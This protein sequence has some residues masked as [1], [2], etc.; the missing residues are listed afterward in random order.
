MAGPVTDAKGQIVRRQ[1]KDEELAIVKLLQSPSMQKQF[2]MAL[3]R[4]ISPER[5]MRIAI[6]AIRRS[7]SL[8]RCSVPSLLGSLLTAAQLGLEVNTPLGFAYLV[9]FKGECTLLVGYQGFL[10]LGRRS[11]LI[12]TPMAT[13][14]YEGDEFEVAYGLYPDI[15]HVASKDPERENKKITHVYAFAHAIPKD[16]APPIFVVLTRAEVLKRKARSAS[17]K[18]G[19]S[20]PWDTDEPMMFKKTGIRALWPWIPKNPEMAGAGALEDA[21]EK[22]RAQVEAWDPQIIEAMKTEG[23]VIE[24]PHD[25]DG[26]VQDEQQ[27]A[28]QNGDERPHTSHAVPPAHAERKS[29]PGSPPPPP[30]E[31]KRAREPGEDG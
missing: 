7:D 28:Q 15:R 12:S 27:S 23:I 8:Q 18:A 10:D 24:M 21:T 16:S 26:V 4:H 14:V 2:A 5:M 29:D 6:T 1:G 31:R 11:G 20:S 9:P 17:V 13:L 30:P 25:D 22:G 19:K 3:P